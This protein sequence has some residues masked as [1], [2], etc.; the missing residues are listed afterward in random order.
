VATG[1]I[2]GDGAAEIVTGAGAGGG[3]HVRVL[4]LANGGLTEIVGFY[5]CD[6]SFE[7]GVLVAAGDVDGDG[8]AEVV[9][10][11]GA[12]SESRVRVF[13]VTGGLNELAAF[14]AYDQPFLGGV[15]VAT[16]DIDG[17]G[18]AEIITGAGSGG[19]PHIRAFRLTDGSQ[20]EIASF[21]AYDPAFPGGVSVASGR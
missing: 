6:P 2:D 4:S 5:A 7:G 1:D 16:G 18:V 11:P 17:D 3:P 12:S 9:T 21:Y 13:A 20:I 8:K 14:D 15:L 10:G 19:G